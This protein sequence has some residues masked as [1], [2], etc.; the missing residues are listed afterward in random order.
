MNSDHSG[1]DSSLCR[2]QLPKGLLHLFSK[3][4]SGQKF[5]FW[6][7][8]TPV[9]PTRVS[10]RPGQRQYLDSHSEDGGGC[11]GSPAAFL[12]SLL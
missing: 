9:T 3:I 12:L 7:D 8:S 11:G 10:A 4:F 6:T 5:P 1:V 2:P